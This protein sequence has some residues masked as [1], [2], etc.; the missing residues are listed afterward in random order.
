MEKLT[1]VVVRAERGVTT[2][3]DRAV[4]PDDAWAGTTATSRRRTARPDTVTRSR[5]NSHDPAPRVPGRAFL[6]RDVGR[7]GRATIWSASRRDLGPAPGREDGWPD[8][9]MPWYGGH[10]REP[11]TGGRPAGLALGPPARLA[12]PPDTTRV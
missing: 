3:S 7:A 12:V 4:G 11:P 6:L 5:G 1:V 10:A 8:H 9:P 2:A